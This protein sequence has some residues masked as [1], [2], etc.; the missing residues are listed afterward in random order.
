MNKLLQILLGIKP[1]PWSA[2]SSWRIDWLALPKHDKLLILLAGVALATWGVL[3]LYRREGRSLS[4]GVRWSLAGLRMVVLL[5]ILA[6][7]LEPAIVFSKQEFV[8]S[9]L[10]V[11]QDR[12]DSMELRDAYVDQ[13]R[14]AHLAEV[15]KLPG[16]ANDLRQQTRLSLGQ[17]ALDAGLREKLATNGDRVIHMRDFAAQLF[18]E[19]NSTTRAATTQATDQ[20]TTAIGAAVRQAIA[21]FRGQPLAGVLVISDGQSNAGESLVKAG[22]FAASEGI[23]IV[24]LAVGTP[25]GPRNAKLTKIEVNP[26]V[27]VRDPNQLQVL[28]ESRGL[29]GAPATLVLEKRRDGGVW[30]EAARQPVTL[31]EAGR[32][33][34]VAFD[35]KEDQPAKLEFRAK[36]EDVGPELTTDDNIATGETRAIRQKIRVLFIAGSTFPEVEFVRNAVLRDPGL[37]ASTWLQTADANYV[38]PG[39]PVLKRLPATPE[40]LNDFDC[41]VLYDPDP[42]LWPSDYAQLLSDFVTN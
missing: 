20:S 21:G 16:G 6:M 33:Q 29:A 5:G 40:E 11:L 35:F 24:A 25:E 8:P 4:I 30:E 42:A 2:G 23:P 12:S 3:W 37:A 14:A 18:P 27:F 15:L 39:N 34:S 7:L 28:V 36:L 38:Q 1:A 22:E 19:T 9:N 13:N 32:L 31:E 41:I 26:V 17:K 10:L